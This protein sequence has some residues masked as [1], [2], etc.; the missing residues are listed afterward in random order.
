MLFAQPIL[1]LISVWASVSMTAGLQAIGVAQFMATTLLA[2][3]WFL[4][5]DVGLFLLTTA[6]T[7]VI[8]RRN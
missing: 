2:L 1:L 3:V 8:G 6:T 5:M 4:A 7:A